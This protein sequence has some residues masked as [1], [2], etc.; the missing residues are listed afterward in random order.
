MPFAS[1]TYFSIIVPAYNR[2]DTIMKTIDSL[3]GQTYPYFEV[4]IADD[5]SSDHTAELFQV[6]EDDR[7]RY[8]YQENA[9]VSAARNFGASKSQYDWLTFL[10]SD[11][12][13]SPHWLADFAE[14]I[15]TS[16]V[17]IIF[18]GMRQI[19]KKFE[20]NKVVDPLDPYKDGQTKGLYNAGT[21]ALKKS[22]YDTVGGYDSKIRFGE[23]TELSIR[24][25]QLNLSAA[26]ISSPNL[27]YEVAEAGG[28]RN[29]ANVIESNLYT[30]QKHKSYFD[31]IPRVKQLYLQT[32]AI[33]Q[34]RMGRIKDGRTNLW[35][36]YFAKP[37][38]GKSFLRAIL[39]SIPTL[40][41]QIWKP[42]F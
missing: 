3:L 24:L 9:G 11:D 12:T 1:K 10:D 34:I 40:A 32:T 25:K 19:N 39:A 30:L 36:A 29:L 27:T 28:A 2:A 4:I 31:N 22:V 38:N 41:K 42:N 5:G 37:S 21:F 18:C 7:I 20:V 17:D 15:E 16:K 33:A 23:N 35:K 8:F 6:V 14:E 13:V 26:Y